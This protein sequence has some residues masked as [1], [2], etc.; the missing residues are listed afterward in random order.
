[1]VTSLQ[2][3]P[4]F[5]S[6]VFFIPTN[7]DCSSAANSYLTELEFARQRFGRSIPLVVSE[8]DQGP[9]VPTNARTLAEL[10]NKHPDQ[11]IHHLTV[12][13]QRTYFEQLFVGEPAAVK[14]MFLSQQRNYGIAMNKLYLMTVSFGADA[15]HRR[16]S[17][18]RLLQEEVPE[19]AGQY[20]I[21]LELTYLGRP[22]GELD[23]PIPAGAEGVK[24]APICVVGG[25]YFGEWNLDVKD[26]ASRSYEIIYRLYEILGF[27]LDKVVDLVHEVFPAEQVYDG[28]DVRTLLLVPNEGANPDC[29]NVAITRIHELLP[30][31]P[32]R[33]NPAADYFS[34]DSAMALGIPSLHHTRT[35]F[36]EYH[37]GRFDPDQKQLYWEGVA[38]FA[39]Y[40]NVYGPLFEPNS[41]GRADASA[42]QLLPPDVRSALSRAISAIPGTARES[43]VARIK[44]MAEEVLIPFDD[45]YARVG[46]HL[47]ANADRYVREAD[48]DYAKHQLLM[49]RWPAIIERARNIDLVK[50]APPLR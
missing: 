2:A 50:L 23:V 32:S 9:Y 27:D 29:G 33:N 44:T 37:S 15:L 11:R 16:D 47:V 3:E 24:D 48:E 22:V 4:A 45:R 14:D 30:N 19:A 18:T 20:P 8:T 10:A 41:V 36:H 38:R 34:F 5:E 43:R 40:F 49:D 6:S 7:R 39:D 26:F 35:V 25:N 28:R 12:D 1:M 42:A 17:D 21:E 46:K 31:T 13:L